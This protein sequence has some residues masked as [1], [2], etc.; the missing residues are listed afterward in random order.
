M[1]WVKPI[2]QVE[3]DIRSKGMFCLVD[4]NR[5]RLWFF[6]Y[7]KDQTDISRAIQ[8]VNGR[9]HEMVNFLIARASY[10]GVRPE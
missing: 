2:D 9:N 7:K 6:G 1:E 3:A 10:R 5:K 4:V 8:S